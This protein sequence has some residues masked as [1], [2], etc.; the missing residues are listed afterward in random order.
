M[1]SVSIKQRKMMAIAAEHPSMLHKKNRGVLKMGK[2]SLKDFAGT[3]EKGLPQ[4]VSKKKKKK[5]RAS[6]YR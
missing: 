4:K 6:R 2:S 3:K 1:P 5:K